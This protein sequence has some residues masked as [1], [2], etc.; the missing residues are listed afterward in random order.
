LSCSMSSGQLVAA[1][2]QRAEIFDGRG[3]LRSPSPLFAAASAVARSSRALVKLLELPSG[4]SGSTP[5]S[6]SRTRACCRTE[7]A[8]PNA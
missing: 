4:L 1:A 3:H 6:T 2:E 7:R 8:P 5:R